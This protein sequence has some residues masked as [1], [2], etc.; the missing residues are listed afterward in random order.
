M[1]GNVTK[2]VP[3][4]RDSPRRAGRRVEVVDRAHGLGAI[5]VPHDPSAI[6]KEPAGSVAKLTPDAFTSPC[7]RSTD[8]TAIERVASCMTASM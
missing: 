8:A 5:R 3:H 7:N 4:R 1:P 6:F 2:A